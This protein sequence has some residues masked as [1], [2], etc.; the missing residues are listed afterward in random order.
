MEV[1][2]KV[3]NCGIIVKDDADGMHD[4]ASMLP[5]LLKDDFVGNAAKGKLSRLV[6]RLLILA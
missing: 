5:G 2:A 6:L 4:K 1:E 3:S